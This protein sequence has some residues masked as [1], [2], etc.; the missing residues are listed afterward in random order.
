MT[1][2][3]VR[4]EPLRTTKLE[5]KAQAH[6]NHAWRGSRTDRDPKVGI[7]DVHISY[8]CIG[9]ADG[10]RRVIRRIK[11]FDAVLEPLRFRDRKTF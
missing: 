11:H 4:T 3:S 6:L 1:S 5:N 9:S 8:V 7:V 10:E 2:M